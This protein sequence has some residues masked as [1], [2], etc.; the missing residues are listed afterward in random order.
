ML[1][2]IHPLSDAPKLFLPVLFSRF[3]TWNDIFLIL[4]VI[5]VTI[6]AMCEWLTSASCFRITGRLNLE[7]ETSER[8][9]TTVTF[10]K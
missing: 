5:I 7:Q 2:I 9:Y 6:V 3:Q 4:I 10:L 1:R 8:R